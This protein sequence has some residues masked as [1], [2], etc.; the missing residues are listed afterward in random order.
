MKKLTV[1][2]LFLSSIASADF[3]VP[4]LPNPVNDYANA[5]T[6]QGK[7]AV[8][9]RIVEFKKETGVQ[10]G[11]LIVSTLD[12]TN[13]EDASV[14]V[15]RKW[16]LG[17]KDENKGLLLMLAISDRKSRIEVGYGL[18][19]VMTDATSKSILTSLRPDLKAKR[20]DQAILLGVESITST[21]KNYKEETATPTTP[22]DKESDYSLLWGILGA[23]GIIGLVRF[24]VTN[25]VSDD[26]DDKPSKKGKKD[27]KGKKKSGRSSGSSHSSSSSSDDGFLSGLLT[28]IASS[29]SSSSGGG[30]SSSDSGS[31]SSGSDWGGGGGDFGGGGSSDSW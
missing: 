24:I 4:A 31:S 2:L 30:S 29:S 25:R 27:N 9:K 3:V 7:E 26:D 22:T 11:V 28:G 14:E 1:A 5:L 6:A 15:A 12:G 19:H 8:A 20:Y 13:I 23:I 18:E 16:K 17:K 10:V 21:I